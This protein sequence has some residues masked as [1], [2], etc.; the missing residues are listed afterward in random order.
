MVDDI[1]GAAVDRRLARE[2]FANVLDERSA[3][4]ARRARA[5]GRSIGVPG[6]IVEADLPGFEKQAEA[7]KA[8]T[9]FDYAPGLAAYAA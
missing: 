7:E 6:S 1:W 8:K 2:G 3:E 5:I 4:E 9:L